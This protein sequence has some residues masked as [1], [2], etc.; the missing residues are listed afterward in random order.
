VVN[1]IAN[2]LAGLAN[3]GTIAIGAVGIFVALRN[4]HRQLNAQMYIEFS[5]RFQ[6]LLRAFPTDA[7]LANADP[8]QPMP[9]AT[10]EATECTLYALQFVADIYHLHEG[11]YLS[12]NL[13]KLWERV[14][15]KTLAGRV[16]R[17]EWET[18]STEFVHSPDFVDYINTTMHSA[19]LRLMS[20]AV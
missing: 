2:L 3:S 4:Q 16:F 15:K 8:S 5:G 20:R 17:R 10:R 1:V 6:E 14:I 19:P 9:A 11:G 13:W 12:E 7:W 18:L